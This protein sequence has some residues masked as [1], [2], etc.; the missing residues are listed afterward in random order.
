MVQ[1]ATV[2]HTYHFLVAQQLPCCR[3]L[4]V[5]MWKDIECQGKCPGAR[6]LVLPW[7]LVVD[8]DL[9]LKM[10]YLKLELKV[11]VGWLFWDLIVWLPYTGDVNAEMIIVETWLRSYCALGTVELKIPRRYL[12]FLTCVIF[13]EG[14]ECVFGSTK[15]FLHVACDELNLIK[16][17]GLWLKPLRIHLKFDKDT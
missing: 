7:F 4:Y 17:V 15:K 1:W 3:Y 10:R 12:D 14:V 11:I 16:M 13:S 2:G 6:P 9:R 5:P 8:L